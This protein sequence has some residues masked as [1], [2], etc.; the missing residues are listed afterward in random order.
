MLSTKP[1]QLQSKSKVLGQFT[2]RQQMFFHL[3]LPTPNTMSMWSHPTLPQ[4]FKRKGNFVY[5]HFKWQ[6]SRVQSITR[7]PKN[8]DSRLKWF[9]HPCLL[10]QSSTR[11]KL[12]QP[13]PYWKWQEK[14]RQGVILLLLDHL[15]I[16][17]VAQKPISYVVGWL[18]K[19]T[20]QYRP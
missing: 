8:C 18:Y 2:F 16:A 17:N 19:R 12:R 15:I 14:F 4:Y 13:F 1:V 7:R 20:A 11:K 6:T 9:W 3:T 5:F 10:S